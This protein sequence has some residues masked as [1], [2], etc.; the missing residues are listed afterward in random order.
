MAVIA[1]G[2]LLARGDNL[3]LSCISCARYDL[4]VP[5]HRSVQ[6][7]FLGLA[8]RLAKFC[9][10]VLGKTIGRR[11]RTRTQRRIFQ[12]AQDEDK[13]VRR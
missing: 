8:F 7:M 9:S 10:E 1:Q 3:R 12:T 5:L 4:I 6:S 11:A 2:D 13:E